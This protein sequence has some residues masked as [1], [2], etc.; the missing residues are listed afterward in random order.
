[1]GVERLED[2]WV[3]DGDPVNKLLVTTNLDVTDPMDR[4]ISLR[5][6]VN[7]ANTQE[8]QGQQQITFGANVYNQTINLKND[9]LEL[10]KSIHI[11]GVGT[12]I[13]VQRDA[14]TGDF[15]LFE[16]TENNIIC[17][18]GGLTLKNGLADTGGAILA[19]GN[20]TLT[21]CTLQGNQAT[22]A[23]G[24]GQGGAIRI[25]G[26]TLDVSGCTITGN[27][28][29]DGGAIDLGTAE[30]VTISDST[31]SLNYASEEGGGIYGIHWDKTLTLHNVNMA[32]N[33]AVNAGGGVYIDDG[34]VATP[35]M[36]L[37]LSGG[38]NIHSNVV[39]S[40]SGKGGG[41][42]LDGGKVNYVSVTVGYN[43]ATT[44]DGLY[45]IGVTEI[46]FPQGLT[47][48]GGDA[49]YTVP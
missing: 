3:P 10:K 38:T 37:V 49:R 41:V 13:T 16:V 42:Y 7:F 28:A 25:L 14:T 26:G 2:R 18:I 48:Q 17:A 5:E 45:L 47:L 1:L 15:R 44:G 23:N 20:L 32:G 35:N 24:W 29:K 43:D 4:Q 22:D 46:N 39:Q 33:I 40:A 19:R 9:R 21:S 8:V 30:A 34:G 11:N 6:A 27:S 36:M 31:I 12:G